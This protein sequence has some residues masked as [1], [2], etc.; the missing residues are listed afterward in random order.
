M[1]AKTM[2]LKTAPGV[3]IVPDGEIEATSTPKNISIHCT[4]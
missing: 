1:G 2:A 4:L 3:A